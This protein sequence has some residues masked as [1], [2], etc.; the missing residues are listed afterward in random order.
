MN[1][2][3]LSRPV[4]LTLVL[5][6]AGLLLYWVAIILALMPDEMKFRDYSNSIVQ[7]WN[8]SFFPLDLL[9]SASVFLGVF[10]IG[11]RPRIADMV[12]MVGL[13]LTFCAGFMAISFWAFSG[14]FDLFWWSSNSWLMAVAVLGFINMARQRTGPA[15]SADRNSSAVPRSTEGT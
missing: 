6:D 11:R 7:A 3:V 15:G 14:D 13:T 12:V 8:W 9:A 5:T 2:Q 4:K 1:K 10:L